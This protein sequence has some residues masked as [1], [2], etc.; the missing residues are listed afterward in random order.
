MTSEAPTL[1]E[2][3]QD[4]AD[5]CR[6]EGATDIAALLDEASA[7]ITAL[8]CERQAMYRKALKDAAEVCETLYAQTG[9]TFDHR[10][11]AAAIL[12]LGK[13]KP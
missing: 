5:L 7:T 3:L 11:C 1:V 2:R 9:R 10:A 4:E 8:M 12:A 13:E 6:N